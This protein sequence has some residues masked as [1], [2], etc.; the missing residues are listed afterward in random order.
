VVWYPYAGWSSAS[1]LLRMDVLTFETCWTLNNEIIKQVTSS[2]STFIQNFDN[3]KMHF[4]GSNFKTTSH[5]CNIVTSPELVTWP[6][7]FKPSVVNLKQL[8]S[9]PPPFFCGQKPNSGLGRLTVEISRSH[10][11][12]Y[13]IGLVWTSDQIVAEAATH[14]TYTNTRDERPW[15]E[16][17]SN[18]QSKKSN[19]RRPT[20]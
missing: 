4:G 6:M 18:P 15:P 14:T 11:I 13:T 2:W 5:F 12:T 20:P 1:V 10:T 19:G 17:D 7:S 3:L 9:S 16:R 8:L